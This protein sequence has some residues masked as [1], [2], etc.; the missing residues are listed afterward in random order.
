MNRGLFLSGET[1][2]SAYNELLGIK[3]W[4]TYVTSRYESN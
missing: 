1:M 3:T 4:L 2:C